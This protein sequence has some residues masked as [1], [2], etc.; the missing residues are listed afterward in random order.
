MLKLLFVVNAGAAVTML[1]MPHLSRTAS[2]VVTRHAQAAP[3]LS[4]L[5]ELVKGLRDGLDD[6]VFIGMSRG[7]WDGVARAILD[8]L[9]SIEDGDAGQVSPKPHPKLHGGFQ[10]WQLP[11]VGNMMRQG[12]VLCYPQSRTVLQGARGT[13]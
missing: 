4:G 2:D 11:A 10:L 13:V 1:H 9:G 5:D 8:G 3:F 6:R 12:A 7:V